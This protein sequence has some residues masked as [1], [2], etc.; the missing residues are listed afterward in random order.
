MFNEFWLVMVVVSDM[1]RSVAFY[2]DVLGLKLMFESEEWSNFQVGHVMLGL[3]PQGPH[4]PVNTSGGVS[5]GFYV[6]SLEATL[7][8]LA[9]HGVSPVHTSEEG[10]GSLAIIPDPDG[11]GIQLCQVKYGH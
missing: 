11:Y 2:R 10:F 5:F 4:L 8:A 3:H 7:A 1:A 9:V 6:P